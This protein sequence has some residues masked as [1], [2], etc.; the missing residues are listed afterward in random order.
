MEHAE[1]ARHNA[2]LCAAAP[3]RLGDQQIPPDVDED[4][5]TVQTHVQAISSTRLLIADAPVFHFSL[6][7]LF[8]LFHS[9]IVFPNLYNEENVKMSSWSRVNPPQRRSSEAAIA[10]RVRPWHLPRHALNR[11]HIR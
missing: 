3:L 6:E 2:P 9:R 8:Y 4:E 1:E 5:N 11:R 10:L 7:F